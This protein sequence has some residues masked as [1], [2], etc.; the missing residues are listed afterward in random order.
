MHSSEETEV[1]TNENYNG[2]LAL[3]IVFLAVGVTFLA[4]SSVSSWIS[5][6]FIGVAGIYLLK[7]LGKKFSA[8]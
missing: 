1:S 6:A 7:Y 5:W 2:L 4:T 8:V 3:G